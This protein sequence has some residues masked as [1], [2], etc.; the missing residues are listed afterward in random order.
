MRKPIDPR[1]HGLAKPE[2]VLSKR[3]YISLTPVNNSYLDKKLSLHSISGIWNK[4][5]KNHLVRED[6]IVEGPYISNGVHL[7]YVWEWDNYD[8]ETQE[9][10]Y[11]LAGE[12]YE[13]ELLKF[14]ASL[15][16]EKEDK[17]NKDIGYLDEKIA[18]TEERLANLKAAKAGEPI[19]FPER[20]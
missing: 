13:A 11:K 7:E 14:E 6:R 17:K 8:Y 5:L 2:R 15:L 1:K 20:F 10:A 12:T 3:E 18:R 9:A 19:P 4:L 16:K